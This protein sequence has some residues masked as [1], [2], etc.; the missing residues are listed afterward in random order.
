[1]IRYFCDVCGKETENTSFVCN[2][3]LKEKF[4]DL[5]SDLPV[6]QSKIR[7]MQALVCKKC[8]DEHF[9]VKLEEK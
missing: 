4:L 1:M 6:P 5:S 3:L 2:I 7:E 8:Y 9:K